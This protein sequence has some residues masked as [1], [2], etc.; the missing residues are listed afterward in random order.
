MKY[1]SISYNIGLLIIASCMPLY[2][3]ALED[4]IYNTF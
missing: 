4:M 3:W 2:I 1:K